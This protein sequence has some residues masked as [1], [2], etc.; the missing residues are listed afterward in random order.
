ME[1]VTVSEALERHGSALPL[2]KLAPG[3]WINANFDIWIGAEEDN[4]AWDQLSEAR[5]FFSARH[6]DAPPEQKQLALEEL[7]VAEGSDWN[8]WYG[9]EH[10]TANDADFDELYRSHLSNVYRALGD[11]PPDSLGQPISAVRQQVTASLPEAFISPVIDGAITN[12]FEWMGAGF[13]SP[14]QTGAAM[15]GRSP[16]MQELHYGRNE[17]NFFLRIDFHSSAREALGNKKLRIVF[18]P[19]ETCAFTVEFSPSGTPPDHSCAVR[20]EGEERNSPEYMA[21][22]ALGKILELRFSFDAIGQKPSAAFE[23]QV[24]ILEDGYAREIFP[25]EGWL[26]VPLPD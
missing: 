21:Q 9:P 1:C 6:R 2:P 17:R 26:T 20:R 10:S 22:G 24:S 25:L 5:D 18:R 8:W 15:H 19:G 7:L 14:L 11:R 4:R 12:Y 23:F 13:Y 16:V 3:S